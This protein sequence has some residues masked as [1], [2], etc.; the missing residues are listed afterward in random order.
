MRGERVTREI[1][2]TCQ[3]EPSVDDGDESVSDSLAAWKASP[4]R[5]AYREPP[6]ASVTYEDIAVNSLQMSA[7]GT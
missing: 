5:F 6:T 2:G 1:A 4:D 3:F 7:I